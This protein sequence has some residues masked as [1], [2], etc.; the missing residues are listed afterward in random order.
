M[1]WC[2]RLFGFFSGGELLVENATDGSVCAVHA[3]LA[4]RLQLLLL[5][6]GLVI[7]LLQRVR[8]IHW[9]ESLLAQF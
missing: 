4:N 2:L 5:L 8:H 7:L 1:L 9:S 3:F 6:L